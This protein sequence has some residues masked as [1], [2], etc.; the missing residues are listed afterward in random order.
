MFI[1]CGFQR[2]LYGLTE[3]IA[4]WCSD[5]SPR[6]QSEHRV[7]LT[8]MLRTRGIYGKPTIERQLKTN[9]MSISHEKQKVTLTYQYNH[10]PIIHCQH[11]L[12]GMC[13]IL[14]ARMSSRYQALA[15]TNHHYAYGDPNSAA[16]NGLARGDGR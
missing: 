12:Y 1:Q 6:A 10:Y 4:F 13:H 7:G 5:G 11:S 14:L 8:S 2:W 3:N 16:F 15:D 9:T